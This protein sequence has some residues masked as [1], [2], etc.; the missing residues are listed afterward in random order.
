MDGGDVIPMPHFG[1]TLEVAGA[2]PVAPRSPALSLGVSSIRVA[3][4]S[5]HPHMRMGGQRSMALL[6]EHL[7]RTVVEPIAICPRPGELSGIF[8]A[9]ACP[10]EFVPLYHIKPRTLRAA[11][12]SSRR[13]RAVLR[14]RGVDVIRPTRLATP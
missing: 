8:T 4:V 10:V 14:E 12:Q 3:F 7:D 6:I 5:H 2:I 9:L 13:I 11:W 1:L